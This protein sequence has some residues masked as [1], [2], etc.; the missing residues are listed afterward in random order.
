MNRFLTREVQTHWGPV[1]PCP[2]WLVSV[3]VLSCYDF[4][5]SGFKGQDYT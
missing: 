4:G 3:R 2:P 1:L 5:V